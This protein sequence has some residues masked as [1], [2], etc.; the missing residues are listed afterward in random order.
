MGKDLFK[1]IP[2]VRLDPQYHLVFG[3]GGEILARPDVPAMEAAIAKICPKDAANFIKFLTDNRI[4]LNEF[5]STLETP[6]HG[7]RDLF[8]MKMV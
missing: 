3:E 1:E 4:K 5:K 8:K 7:W 6:F 2:M